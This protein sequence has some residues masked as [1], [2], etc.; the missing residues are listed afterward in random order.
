L[1]NIITTTIF[2]ST[3]QDNYKKNLKT[4]LIKI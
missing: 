3:F 4:L 2:E 1:G